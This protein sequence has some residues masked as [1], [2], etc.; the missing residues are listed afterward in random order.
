MIGTVIVLGLLLSFLLGALVSGALLQWH[1]LLQTHPLWFFTLFGSVFACCIAGLLT[2]EKVLEWY[3][4][5][6]Y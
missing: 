5:F 1:S 2:L 6:C 3:Q 4:I